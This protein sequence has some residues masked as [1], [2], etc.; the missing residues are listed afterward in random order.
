MTSVNG[1]EVGVNPYLDMVY[2]VP[3]RQGENPVPVGIVS[4][5]YRL[6]DHHQLLRTIQEVLDDF[7]IESSQLQVLGEWTTHGERARFSLI[8]PAKDRFNV[9]LADGDEMRF[10]IEVFN[11][12]EGSAD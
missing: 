12:V 6:V 10:R 2:Q 8:F 3:T 1:N 4:K 11:S 9:I 7:G 5:N